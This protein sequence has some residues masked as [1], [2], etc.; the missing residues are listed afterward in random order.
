MG[1]PR[2]ETDGEPEGE[3]NGPED[4]APKENEPYA[5]LPQ[6]PAG[7][8]NRGA[9]GVGVD[10]CL[11]VSM[12]QSLPEGVS[13]TVT[14]LGLD[15]TDLLTL[16]RGRCDG[17][18]DCRNFTFTSEGGSCSVIF[19]AKAFRDDETEGPD[20]SLKLS[21]YVECDRGAETACADWV[22]EAN[23]QDG[24]IELRAPY[25]EDEQQQPPQTNTPGGEPPTPDD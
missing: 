7:G 20:A 2:E 18:P 25:K 21:G 16:R 11:E 8:R 4:P 14:K 22:T 17:R 9:D 5:Q 19:V 23:K 13:A 12:L 3:G 15:R 6:L 10:S 1:Q 24:T